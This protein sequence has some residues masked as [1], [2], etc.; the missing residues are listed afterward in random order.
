MTF[1][2]IKKTYPEQWVLIDL[3]DSESGVANGKVL[4]HGKDYLEL[5]YKS[6]QII[7]KSITTILY[8]GQQTHNRKWLKATRLSEKPKTI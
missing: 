4:L 1:E 3:D 5:C 8:T 7:K 2:Q 6:N